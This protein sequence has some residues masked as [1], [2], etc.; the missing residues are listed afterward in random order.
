[1][2]V[3]EAHEGTVTAIVDGADGTIISASTDGCVKVW[4]VQAGRQLM[5]HPFFECASVV[6]LGRVWVTALAM[7]TKHKWVCYAA[8]SAGTVRL[9]HRAGGDKSHRIDYLAGVARGKLTLK[10][11]WDHVHALGIHAL[12]VVAERSFLISLSYDGT[13]KVLDASQGS[14]YLSVTNPRRGAMYT[15]VCLNEQHDH[16][17][18]C[19]SIGFVEVWSAFTDRQLAVRNV[20]LESELIDE[21]A[22]RASQRASVT[23]GGES[24]ALLSRMCLWPSVEGVIALSPRLGLCI[25][26]QIQRS[27]CCRLLVGH[28]EAVIALSLPPSIS[29]FSNAFQVSRHERL[30][31]SAGHDNTVRCWDE[32]ES[33]Q[34]YFM[35]TSTTA[36]ASLSDIS[37]MTALWALHM[38]AT[39][40]YPSV[41]EASRD[42][43]A[44]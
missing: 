14:L 11:Q 42:V 33:A 3:L 22:Q 44:Y 8:D 10:Q 29:A 34:V 25:A 7:N 41:Q 43:N 39:G 15:S 18:L 36:S 37:C 9:Y 4:M 13:C 38:V 20:A 35:S 31:F 28:D 26:W 1:V 27:G 24:N 30:A 21:E 17:Y 2:Q 19:D 23:L 6:T 12:F 5:L 40:M 16:L 32:Y